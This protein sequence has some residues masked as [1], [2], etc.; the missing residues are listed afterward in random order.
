M[1]CDKVNPLRDCL[2]GGRSKSATLQLHP[3]SRARLTSSQLGTSTAIVL[4]LALGHAHALMSEAIPNVFEAA[5]AAGPVMDY[6]FFGSL[7]AGVPA[8]DCDMHSEGKGG[9]QNPQ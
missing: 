3:A 1:A 6:S 8:I 7:L 4:R 5:L 9:L 2:R